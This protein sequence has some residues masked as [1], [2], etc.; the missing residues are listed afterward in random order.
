MLSWLLTLLTVSWPVS[1]VLCAFAGPATG[2]FVG[3]WAHGMRGA[4]EGAVGG[5]VGDIA[6]FL[7]TLSFLVRPTR[8]WPDPSMNYL[9]AI[10]LAL[11]TFLL[12]MLGGLTAVAIPM[13]F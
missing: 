9:A 6:G 2:Y 12:G 10:E 11:G 4:I 1:A 7:L 3:G 8:W 13:M 5:I